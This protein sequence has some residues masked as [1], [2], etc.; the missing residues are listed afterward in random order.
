VISLANRR[1][2]TELIVSGGQSSPDVY[3]SP[4][5]SIVYT[6]RTFPVGT[7]STETELA[8][9]E[10]RMRSAGHGFEIV[11]GVAPLVVWVVLCS[12]AINDT[13]VVVQIT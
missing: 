8:D 1:T 13:A 10:L 9:A 12:R 6:S 7:I 3:A 2:N 5:R 4:R 11:V